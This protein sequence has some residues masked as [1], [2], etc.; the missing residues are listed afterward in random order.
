MVVACLLA[1]GYSMGLVLCCVMFCFAAW[2]V[3]R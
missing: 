3:G 2:V 1:V